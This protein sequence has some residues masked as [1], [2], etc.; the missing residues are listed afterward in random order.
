MP[1]Q[2]GEHLP[3]QVASKTSHIDMI[4]SPLMQDLVRRFEARVDPEDESLAPWSHVDLAG[5][6]PL[7]QAVSSDG[8]LQKVTSDDGLREICFVRTARFHL[9]TEDAASIDPRFPHPMQIQ[10]LM[11]DAAIHCNAVFPLRNMQLARSGSVKQSIRE[12]VREII[13][14]EHG[15]LMYEALKW[16]LFQGWGPETESPDVACPYNRDEMAG[17]IKF[18]EDKGR[19][20]NCGRTVYLTDVLG[21]H[22]DMGDDAAGEA[23]ANAYMA[24]HEVLLLVAHVYRHWRSGDLAAID[25]TLLVKDGPLMFRGQYAT[26]TA[27]MRSMLA[28]LRREGTT[29]YLVSQEK[30]GQ[31]F[32]HLE[33]QLRRLRRRPEAD[34]PQVAILPHRYIRRRI[35][36]LP[37]AADIYG[38]RT[39]YGEKVLVRLDPAFA[40][41]VNIPTGDF[42]RSEDRPASPEDFIGFH[43]IIATLPHLVS[44]LHEGSLI[45]INLAHGIASLSDYPSTAALRRFAGIDVAA[46]QLR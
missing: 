27:R 28:H 33:S 37:E 29:V 43:R 18:N 32:D 34:W 39:N 24:I 45:P 3:A 35:H 38:S 12:L 25:D 31:V 13:T 15:G 26:L 16:L 36:R 6:P 30:S 7:S 44:Y 17:P 4:A 1:Y 42:L 2:G 19:C 5:I 23:V 40:M 8:S 46:D 10:N 21:L 14:Y 41:V 20:R 9:R 22:L 11:K